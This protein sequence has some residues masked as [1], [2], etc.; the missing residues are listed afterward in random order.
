MRE[1][2]QLLAEALDPDLAPLLS[3][4]VGP[5]AVTGWGR[6]SAG[7]PSIPRSAMRRASHWQAGSMSSGAGRGRRG[8]DRRL[9]RGELDELTPVGHVGDQPRRGACF[10]FPE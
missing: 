7:W 3:F 9:A 5:R 2:S 1:V 4:T 6:L 10:R 8:R